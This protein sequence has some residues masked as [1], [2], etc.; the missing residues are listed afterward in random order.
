MICAI[1]LD[2]LINLCSRVKKR[3]GSNRILER[4][5]ELVDEFDFRFLAFNSNTYDLT[6]AEKAKYMIHIINLEKL[7]TG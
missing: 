6:D 3:I 2:E 1:L 7:E 5:R 4:E